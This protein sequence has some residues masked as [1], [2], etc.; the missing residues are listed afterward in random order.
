MGKRGGDCWGFEESRKKKQSP[1]TPAPFQ[2]GERQSIFGP[3]RLGRATNA[4][5]EPRDGQPSLGVKITRD[6][7]DREEGKCNHPITPKNIKVEKKE[8]LAGEGTRAKP[9][10]ETSW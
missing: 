8:I 1:R 6:L 5:G 4:G 2:K 9:G 3:N 7:V 10:L